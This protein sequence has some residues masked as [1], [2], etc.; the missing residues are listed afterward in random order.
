MTPVPAHD[1]TALDRVLA[2]LAAG[3]GGRPTPA[4]LAVTVVVLVTML[5]S[6]AVRTGGYVAP[7]TGFLLA[8]VGAWSPLLARTYLPVVTL[9]AV[10]VAESFHLAFLALPEQLAAP[11]SSDMGA[12]QPV[13]LATML[14][15]YTVASRTPRR[16]G[17][18][19]GIGGALVLLTV[20]VVSH[21]GTLVVTDMVMLNLVLIATGVGVMVASRRDRL[22][23]EVRERDDDKRQAVLDERLRI[24][25]ELHD[26][27][28]HN[29]TL[30][31]AQAGV[32]EYLMRTDPAAASTA[33]RDIARH[34]GQ[35]IDEL[36]ATV[37]LLRT[38][39]ADGAPA[40]DADA[41]HPV[42]G[43]DRLAALVDGFRTAGVPVDLATT[44]SPGPGAA[45]GQQGDLAAYRIVQEALTN[46]TKH[47]PGVAVRVTL[48]WTADALT[49]D[50]GNGPAP[51]PAVRA[52]G[53]GHG[54]IGM[55]ERAVAA[56]G[57]LT[58]A[59][60]PDGGFAVRATLPRART[61]G[62]PA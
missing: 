25:R 34:T 23:R 19:A 5:A 39:G 38:D 35:A 22:S 28:A 1:P 26:V 24:A 15:A 20:A 7:S 44:G 54:L 27:L 12:Y 53:T 21:P 42:P 36:R 18:S 30:V 40:E 41:R 33:L 49:V 50:V 47:A 9:L 48:R 4:Q 46:A 51:G 43:L 55:R 10:L 59:P 45:L 2:V 13:P 32:A 56:G 58:A 3:R 8:V 14:A 29:L 60:T 11:G 52:A 6:S 17:W 61:E 62:V 16:I 37:G 57:T 31:N